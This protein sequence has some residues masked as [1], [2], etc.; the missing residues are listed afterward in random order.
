MTESVSADNG[1]HVRGRDKRLAL[2]LMTHI[3]LHVHVVDPN[4][5]N[6]EITI[7]ISFSLNFKVQ[8]FGKDFQKA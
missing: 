3:Y 1:S 7:V 2:F 5:T 4:K 8:C 6:V